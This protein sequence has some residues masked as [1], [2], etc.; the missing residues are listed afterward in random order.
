MEINKSIA[1]LTYGP[2]NLGLG[3]YL[4]QNLASGFFLTNIDKE[5]ILVEKYKERVLNFIQKHKTVYMS[6][7]RREFPLSLFELQL[8][9]NKLKEEG[10]IKIDE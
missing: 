1:K 5:E 9:I 7:L 2:I 6:D 4:P 8:V 3:L 10:K